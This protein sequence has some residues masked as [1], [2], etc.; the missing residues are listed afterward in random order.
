MVGGTLAAQPLHPPDRHHGEIQGV[1]EDSRFVD[2]AHRPRP[3]HEYAEELVDLTVRATC[4]APLA[5]MPAA[6]CGW[7]PTSCACARRA[8]LLACTR[9]EDSVRGHLIGFRAD[10]AMEE[11]RMVEAVLPPDR[12][13]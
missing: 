12:E 7:S 9:L 3:G 8:P 5:A 11:R 6:T 4:T 10:P 2:P 1:L 13:Q